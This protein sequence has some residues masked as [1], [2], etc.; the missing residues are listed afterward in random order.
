MNPEMVANLL[1][2]VVALG[3]VYAIM[4]MGLTL[5]Y[6]VTKIFN[7]AQGSFYTWGA[8]FAWILS[9]GVF[10]L[11]Y[12]LAFAITIGIMFLFG[13][14]YERAIM[15]PLRRYADWGFIAIIVTLGSALLL[16]NLALVCFGPRAKTLPP[17]VEGSFNFGGFTIGRHDVVVLLVCM[18]IVIVLTLF[19]GRAREGMAMRG[20]AQDTV[21]AQITGISI[22][23][24]YSYSFA[25]TAV[26]A[27]IAGMLLSPRTMIFPAGG[28]G[29]LVKAFVVMVFGGLGSIKGTLYAAFILAMV[30]VFVTYFIG[31][32]WGLPIFLVVLMGLLLIRPRGLYG[33]W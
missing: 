14:G 22:N 13:L 24:V 30:E 17:L 25:I 12:R 18:A 19:L 33:I 32:V 9:E 8:Y 21:G 5:V 27:G 20:A 28:W 31:S 29:I 26:L 4:A 1:I 3:A 11:D 10:H 6:G 15:Y 16:D 2:V 7:Y 23:R